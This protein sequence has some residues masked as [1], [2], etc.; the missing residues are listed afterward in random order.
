MKFTLGVLFSLA[1]VFPA[2]AQ[3][4]T[5]GLPHPEDP[6]LCPLAL[7]AA[8][9][10]LNSVLSGMHRAAAQTQID[11]QDKANLQHEVDELKKENAALKAKY[12]PKPAAATPVPAPKK[13]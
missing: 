3:G 5:P 2:F 11:T 12:E 4:V 9:A 1:F 7:N 8:T 6:R 13:D 10:D